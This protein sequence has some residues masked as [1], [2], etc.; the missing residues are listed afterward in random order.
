MANMAD[1][2]H[3]RAPAN[4]TEENPSANNHA[5]EELRHLIIAPE[6]EE[7]AD[8]QERLDDRARRTQDVSSVVA[9]AIS[10]RRDQHGERA[11][12]QAL[13][14][15]VQETLRESV[16]RDPHPLA[17]ALFPVMGPAIRKSISEA[18]RSMLESFNEALEH[19]LSVRGMKWRI[20][21]FRTGK[22]FAEIV[23]MHS[24]LFRVEQVFLIHRHTG[25]VLNHVV[26]R[27]VATQDASMVAGML[28]AIQQ[29][30]RDSFN[31]KND[32][33]LDRLDVGELEVWIEEGP[34]AVLA[35][36][37]RGHAPSDYRLAMK[38]ALE[39]I[40][41]RYSSALENFKGDAAPFLSA[42]ELLRRL[43]AAQHREPAAQKKPRAALATIA[44][45]CI[46]LVAY[47][48]YS[49]YLMVEWS[50]ILHAVRGQPG[51][52]VLSYD[53]EGGRYHIQGFKDP[54]APDPNTLLKQAGLDPRT[55]QFDLAPYYSLDDSIVAQRAR[56]L[57]NPPEGVTLSESH[58]E[59]HVEGIAAPQ[60]ISRAQERAPYIA[61]VTSVD[62]SQL[63]N[64]HLLQLNGPKSS[65]ESMILV[66][67]IGRAELEPGQE[68]SVAQA[69]KGIREI[70]EKAS[71]LGEQTNVELTGHSDSTGI[72]GTNMLLSQER[73]DNIRSI[74]IRGGVQPSN[75]H[76]RG[77][78]ATQPLRPEDTEE[79][80]RLNRSV[81]A[82]I[83]FTPTA[84][85]N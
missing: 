58:G 26:A 83:T 63:Q 16:R 61:G 5:Y 9:E 42:E 73:A 28:S 22:P 34:D 38:E 48:G 47:F 49:I 24:L 45:L 57:L 53:H 36:V 21:A 3:R 19:S 33:S 56:Q 1:Q 18:L 67:P 44:V 81:T 41:Q 52:V 64:S 75:L 51:I 20:E 62:T 59:L 25:L 79:N 54:L 82:R 78:G 29:F 35:A 80:R 40:Q 84:S 31:S 55:A 7:L 32:E 2:A 68:S 69:Q 46:L 27:E 60:W 85:G 8:I 6:Q 4:Q 74:L 23:V 65:I 15:T 14:P 50:R 10:M 12:A 76:T 17:D 66:F 37:I 70:V 71:H 39:E 13:A 11:L 43:L 72:E 30:V 77:V